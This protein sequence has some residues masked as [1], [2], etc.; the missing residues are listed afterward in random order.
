MPP[1][2]LRAGMW[3]STLEIAPSTNRGTPP[4]RV[5]RELTRSPPSLGTLPSHQA[6]LTINPAF[7]LTEPRV[8]LPYPRLPAYQPRIEHLDRVTHRHIISAAM[9]VTLNSRAA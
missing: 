1:P 6:P 2:P 7:A 3:S 8:P 9:L 5:A 4:A